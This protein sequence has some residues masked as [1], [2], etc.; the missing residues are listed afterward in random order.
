M[1]WD[2]VLQSGS[3]RD[4]LALPYVLWSKGIRIDEIAKLGS[5]C[6]RNYKIQF[7]DHL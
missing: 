7:A 5:N 3:G 2:E 1:W 6:Y 4:Q